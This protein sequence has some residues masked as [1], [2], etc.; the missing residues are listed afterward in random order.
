MRRLTVGCVALLAALPMMA[1]RASAEADYD[2]LHT[3]QSRQTDRVWRS[4]DVQKHEN[5]DVQ[6]A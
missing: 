3:H 1:G 6:P 5:G 4:R 2:D